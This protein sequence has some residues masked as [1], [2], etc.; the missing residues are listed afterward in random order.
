M[1]PE[2][3]EKN[4]YSLKTDSFAFGILFYHLVTKQFPWSGNNRKELLENYA[5]KPY[6]LEKIGHLPSCFQNFLKG[7]CEI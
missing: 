7:L 1:P 5:S 2:T 3:L 4:I 6:P